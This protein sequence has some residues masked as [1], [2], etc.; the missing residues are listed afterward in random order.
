MAANAGCAAL[1]VLSGA[2]PEEILERSQP[3]ACLPDLTAIPA[4]LES[5]AARPAAAAV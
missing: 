5:L 3:L 1:G 4:F 2:Q